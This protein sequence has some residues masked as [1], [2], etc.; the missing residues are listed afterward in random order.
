MLG[1]AQQHRHLEAASRVGIVQFQ[2]GHGAALLRVRGKAYGG[3]G[4]RQRGPC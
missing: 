4:Q 2:Q 3:C 1:R